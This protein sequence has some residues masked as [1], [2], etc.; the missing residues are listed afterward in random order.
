[1]LQG[2]VVQPSVVIGRHVLL[3]ANVTVAHDCVVNDYACLSTGVDLAGTVHIGEGACLRVGAVVI[4]N[5]HVGAWAIVGPRS[6]VTRDVP[7][8]LHVAGLPA[9]PVVDGPPPGDVQ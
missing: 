7:D 9:K 1:M 5:V 4:P 8:N 3:A 6:A 2:A